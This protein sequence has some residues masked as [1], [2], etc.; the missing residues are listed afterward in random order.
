MPIADLLP[1]LRTH[2]GGVSSLA[3][4]DIIR[5]ISTWY[6]KNRFFTGWHTVTIAA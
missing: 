2:T 1:D 6:S 5:F 3:R 4:Y